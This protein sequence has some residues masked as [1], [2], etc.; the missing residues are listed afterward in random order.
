M[1]VLADRGV[2]WR[3]VETDQVL[4]QL[5]AP[6]LAHRATHMGCNPVLRDSRDVGSLGALRPEGRPCAPHGHQ[7][8]LRE[9]AC[10]I[11]IG[12]VARRKTMTQGCIVTQDATQL[13]RIGG[14][15]PCSYHE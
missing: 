3:G 15:G 14:R 11:S 5:R 13:R 10:P 8:F 9:I 4:G 7:Y 1:F 12:L 6:R 2:F